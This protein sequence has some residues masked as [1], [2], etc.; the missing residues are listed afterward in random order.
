MKKSL[1]VVIAILVVF[2]AS[3]QSKVDSLLL[4]CDK[5]SN[6]QEKANIYIKLSRLTIQ[7]SALSNSYNKKA[8]EL[9]L[10]N[11]LTLEQGN[12]VYQFGKI[13]FTARDF[14]GAIKY[15][16]KAI[17][18]FRQ[19][20]DTARLTTCYSYIGIANFN[21]SRSKEAIAAYLEG[22]KLSKNDPDYSA[23]LLANIGLVHDEMDNF[24]Q[25]ITYFRKALSI[26]LS[27]HD[28]VSMGIDY[29]YL[30]ASYA[31]FKMPDSAI[32]NYHKAL[33]LF[34][35]TGKND[36]YAISL[37]NIASVFPNYP[38]SLNKS[39]DYFHRAWDKFQKLG[40]LHYEADI[41]QGI[42]KVLTQQGKYDEAISAY[43]RSRQIAK[44][45][46][47]ELLIWKEL[48]LGL[49]EAYEKKGDFKQALANHILYSQYTDSVTKKSN[50][51]LVASLEKQ[52]ETEKKENEYNK[53]H[54]KNELMNVQ[55]AKD[56]QLKLLGFFTALLLVIIIFILSKKYM[57]KIKAAE[58]LSE[59]NK[60]I[61]QSE[62]EL[63]VLNAAKNKFF[64]ILAHD[65]KNPF[66]TV[67]G[68]SFLLSNNYE[69]F[70]DKERHKFALDINK[71]ANNIFRL[72]ENLLE[73]SKTQTG[74]LPY[75]PM[76]IE[77]KQ[78]IDNSLNV[79][80]AL[81][82]QKNIQL[83]VQYN[84]NIKTYSDPRMM[85]TVLRNLISNAI[86][87]TPE[88]GHINIEAQE[89]ESEVRIM[90]SDTG[91]GLA[92]EELEHLFRIDSK[93][94]RKGTNNEDGSGIGLILCR[95]FVNMN[96]GRLWAE[97][98]PGKGSTFSFTIPACTA[99]A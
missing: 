59:K 65:L 93:V 54:A 41:Q 21:M 73:W 72:L 74:S 36:R 23:E 31:R 61:A 28:S 55:L 56:K 94:K 98:T 9:A 91:I 6:V 13:L 34:K 43:N 58:L 63:R 75:N 87:F 84:Q 40:W 53:L 52:Y 68:Y 30:G 19:I 39:I 86:K 76:E 38:D 2:I 42:A 83:I 64:S 3:S 90:V 33:Y 29:D 46:N 78:I 92:N 71:S 26:N 97:S 66:H 44:K 51:E 37:S 20:N 1:L 69:S 8:Y 82:E 57:D 5:S 35:K 10:A 96:K 81:A 80:N 85:E 32:V 70:S 14:T 24:D 48:Y 27:I 60:I 15:Y 45:Y 17:P 77:L 95:E 25:A 67:M 62:Q 50:F 18:L 49:S 11:N 88:G 79:L 47:R 4:L 7:D 16:E 99:V 22:L 12:A 89:I